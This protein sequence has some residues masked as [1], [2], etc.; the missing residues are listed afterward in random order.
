MG[1]VRPCWRELFAY[2]AEMEFC[3]NNHQKTL[4]LLSF[5][6]GILVPIYGLSHS[7]S[8]KTED[9]TRLTPGAVIVFELLL[10]PLSFFFFRLLGES[11]KFWRDLLASFGIL[12]LL[13]SI[14]I[15]AELIYHLFDTK[16]TPTVTSTVTD[17]SQ[18]FPQKK[19]NST[20]QSPAAPASWY[21]VFTTSGG[22]GDSSTSSFDIKGA[23]WRI[24]YV[25][26]DQTHFGLGQFNVQP[27]TIN[28]YRSGLQ[29][30]SSTGNA[31]NS[32]VEH[33]GAGT[34]YLKIHGF[35][36]NYSITV[37]DYY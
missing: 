23:Q 7:L 13:I 18:Y 30:A 32:V 19:L 4:I 29:F 31:T 3:M 21:T 22:N 14:L 6:L 20:K 15:G 10:I 36:V 25:V 16:P 5:L 34:Y 9:I 33:S 1:V 17:Y 12:I 26:T 2:P 35:N 37:E 28:E 11:K 8:V 27:Q 24:N